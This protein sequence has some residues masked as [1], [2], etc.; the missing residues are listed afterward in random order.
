M[1]PRHPFLSFTSIHAPKIVFIPPRAVLEEL[2]VDRPIDTCVQVR[3]LTT[4][5]FPGAPQPLQCLLLHPHRM[6][7]RIQHSIVTGEAILASIRAGEATAARWTTSVRKDPLDP[8]R[9]ADRKSSTP[10]TQPPRHMHI[11][12]PPMDQSFWRSLPEKVE[13]VISKS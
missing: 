11:V 3:S 12:D 8:P 7:P 2:K 4:T 10:L 6:L 5:V 13:K 9:S 1:N